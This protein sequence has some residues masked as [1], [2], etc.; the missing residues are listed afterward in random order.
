MAVDLG[1]D[2]LRPDQSSTTSHHRTGKIISQ[3]DSLTRQKERI[4]YRRTNGLPWAE[5][6]FALRDDVVGQEDQ[7]FFDGLPAK[8]RVEVKKLE[9]A[10]KQ[11]AADT[12][13]EKYA[14]LGWDGLVFRAKRGRTGPK[15]RPTHAQLSRAYRI[16]LR[17]LDR[18]GLLWNTHPNSKLN[19]RPREGEDLDPEQSRSS[20][21]VE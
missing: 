6:V 10:G 7:E 12:I 2:H 1:P 21:D 17:L 8:K 18:Q 20:S 14:S 9:D 11:G 15:Y 16:I 13:R 19:R 3:V 5:A 4:D